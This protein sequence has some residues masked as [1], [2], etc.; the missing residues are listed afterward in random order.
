MN[1]A[2]YVRTLLTLESLRDWKFYRRSCPFETHS[3]SNDPLVR[4]K[5]QEK[6]PSWC[7]SSS[8]AQ[9]HACEIKEIMF[10]ICKYLEQQVC[11]NLILSLYQLILNWKKSEKSRRNLII[12][13]FN[14]CWTLKSMASVCIS[15]N[16]IKLKVVYL[17]NAHLQTS[18]VLTKPE[19]PRIL[20]LLPKIEKLK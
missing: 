15:C 3:A 14:L 17:T 5:R 16:M 9:S 8:H 12:E 11:N 7:M 10:N 1:K 20:E 13:K 6:E 19:R 4:G 2:T 18:R